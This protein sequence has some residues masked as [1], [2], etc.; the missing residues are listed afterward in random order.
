MAAGPWFTVRTNQDD[1]APL[2]SIWISNGE[3]DEAATVEYRS[4]LEEA[5]AVLSDDALAL[6]SSEPPSSKE[7]S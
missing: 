1:W 7:G 6:H 2:D 5:P 3:T 4:R